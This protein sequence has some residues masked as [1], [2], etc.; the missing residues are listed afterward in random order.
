M[1]ARVSRMRKDNVIEALDFA[2]SEYKASI[3]NITIYL[4]L[5]VLL[6]P[7]YLINDVWRFCANKFPFSVLGAVQTQHFIPIPSN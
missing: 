2:K 4:E 3:R 5:T 1:H 6:A 7:K